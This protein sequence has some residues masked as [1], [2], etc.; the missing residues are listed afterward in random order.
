MVVTLMCAAVLLPP[1]TSYQAERVYLPQE[2]RGSG[3]LQAVHYHAP[4]RLKNLFRP[5]FPLVLH[6]GGGLYLRAL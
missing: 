1:N 4:L 5:H 3:G 6:I 2:K